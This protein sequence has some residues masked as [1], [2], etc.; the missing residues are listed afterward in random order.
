MKPVSIPRQYTK[1]GGPLCSYVARRNLGLLL[2]EPGNLEDY[3]IYKNLKF[4]P[5]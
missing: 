1:T 2:G 4:A 3:S 5:L